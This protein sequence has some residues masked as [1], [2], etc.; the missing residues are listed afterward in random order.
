MRRRNPPVTKSVIRGSCTASENVGDAVY[1][2]GP[3]AGNS[4][5][6]AR[7]DCNDRDRMPAVGF[8]I[9]KLS[10]VS[11]VVQTADPVEGIFG[12]ALVRG[13]TYLVGTDGSIQNNVATPGAPAGVTYVQFVGVAM[14]SNTLLA[15]PDFNI[16]VRTP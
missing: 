16:K 15:R 4:Y 9:A 13:K 14:A 8:I 2:S 12:G 6:V 3:K 11:C 10:A 1:V 7:A 5:P